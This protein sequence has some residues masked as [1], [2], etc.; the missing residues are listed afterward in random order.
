MQIDD[1]NMTHYILVHYL[2][3]HVYIVPQRAKR[4]GEFMYSLAVLLFDNR[5]Y[6]SLDSH[7]K[8]LQERIENQPQMT[9]QKFKDFLTPS[10]P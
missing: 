7:M 2:G 1:L 9:F 5:L 6:M 10:V 4:V 3:V 8:L